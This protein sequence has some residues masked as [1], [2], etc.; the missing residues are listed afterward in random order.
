MDTILS[1]G[2]EHHLAIT[3]GDYLPALLSLAKMLDIP[4]LCL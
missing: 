1:E 4:V 2:L 3:Y